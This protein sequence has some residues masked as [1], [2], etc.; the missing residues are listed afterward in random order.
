MKTNSINFILASTSPRRRK[1]FKKIVDNYQVFSPDIE[2]ICELSKPVEIVK[3]LARQKCEAAC[4]QLIESDKIK[5]K[6]VVISAD[7]LV[8]FE[9]K[10]LGKPQSKQEAYQML[11]RLQN[12]WHIVNSGIAIFVLC[13]NSIKQYNTDSKLDD[14]LIAK[15]IFSDRAR[16]LM[17]TRTD[18]QT[19]AYI[20]SGA[21][22][23]KAGA[24][25]I[26]DLNGA[27]VA[28]IE[29]SYDNVVGLPTE[30]IITELEKL[31]LI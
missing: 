17:A 4:K 23:D 24:Y 28:K 16:V 9:G 21:P 31:D 11:T 20:K 14:F 7:T 29:G 22:M 25:G 30:K 26:Q 5:Q 27:L 1:L 2:E 19:R 10:L 8:E 15:S 3:D 18:D 12:K 6:T 13:E